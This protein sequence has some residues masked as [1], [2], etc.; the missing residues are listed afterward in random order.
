[1]L[2]Y[3]C[4]KSGYLFAAA[5]LAVVGWY[6]YAP[7][8]HAPFVF[9]DLPQ[10][11]E[12]PH[13]RI[14]GYSS[15]IPA[16]LMNCRN[17]NR[18]LAYATFALNYYVHQYDV[19]G[20]RVV[21]V[22]IH[23]ITAFLVFLTAR[24]TLD[25]D[26]RKRSVLLPF[27]AAA[28]WMV[29][30]VH[31]QS[32]TYIVQRMNAMAAMFTL[33]ALCCFVR[34]R[35]M[36]RSGKHGLKPILFYAGAGVSGLCGLAAKETTAI[37]P[38]VMMLYEWYFFQDLSRNWMKKQLARISIVL[39]L[40][41]IISLVY[42]GGHP[43][44]KLTGIYESQ[45]FT[46]GQR[47]LTEPRVVLYYLTLLFFPHPTRLNLDYN[48]PLSL[49]LLNPATTLP[50]ILALLGLVVAAAYTAKKHRLCSFAIAWFLVTLVIESSFIGLALVFEHRTYLPSVFPAIAVT[51]F[52]VRQVKPLPVGVMIVIAAIILC[53]YNTYQRNRVWDSTLAFWQDC[54]AKF[55]NKPRI[56]NNLGMAYKEI[57]KTVEARRAFEAAL[58]SDPEWIY[59]L[60]NLGTI[61]LEEDNPEQAAG[62]FE[63]A[64]LIEPGYY[65]AHYNLG[66]AL[67]E[68]NRVG[69][70]IQSFKK[71]LEFNPFYEKAH[72]NLGAALIQRLD[73]DL[74]IEHFQ[75]TLSLDP[76]FS[77]AYSN[78]GVAFY[79]KGMV[80]KAIE[81]FNKTL[82]IDPFHLDAYNNMRWVKSKSK[83]YRDT[84]IGLKKRLARDPDNPRLCFRLAETYNRA[85]MTGL[86]LEYYENALALQPNA[87]DAL[88][89]MGDFYAAH[90]R[91]QLAADIYERLADLRPE[92]A[93][94]HYNLACLYAL[95]NKPEKAVAELKAAVNKGYGDWGKIAS[96]KDLENIHD[97][98]YFK[99]IVNNL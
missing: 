49:S 81:C 3:C 73:L 63:K 11:I 92:S 80:D 97:T 20:Y 78:L 89:I 69:P 56:L 9:D 84:I 47:L 16:R 77:Q 8:F 26:G 35:L 33:L 28:L 17:P 27:L 93:N 7:A 21:N 85:G 75:R 51:C 42:M 82:D 31:T 99:K 40:L 95:Q 94:V 64:I 43:V 30:P 86:A 32:V 58:A 36:Q 71:A 1:M 52:L 14:T 19:A 23:I 74:A 79:K 15:D 41:V 13:I 70:A 5:I 62:F 10:I 57:N 44:D 54:R 68:M 61:V 90:Y 76:F 59:A 87:I 38:V 6:L 29:N 88:L 37:L 91:Y 66:L 18:F 60:N 24:L 22:V 96:D 12:N 39:V 55:P 2:K 25:P 4:S 46:P 45:D 83:K 34:A 65:E 98:A 72:N 53:G 67:M 48:F 50:A